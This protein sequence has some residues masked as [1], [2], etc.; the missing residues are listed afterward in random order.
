MADIDP[1][2][3]G[4][5]CANVQATHDLVKDMDEKQDKHHDRLTKLESHN[6]MIKRAAKWLAG[7]V[8][9]ISSFA[10]WVLS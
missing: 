2:E 5:L 10:A 9:A 6:D 1:V 4:K 8:T 3:F 7:G